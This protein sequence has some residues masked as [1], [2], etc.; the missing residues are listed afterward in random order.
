EYAIRFREDLD[1]F[2]SLT[3]CSPADHVFLPTAHGR[4]LCA[5]LEL[6]A[7]WP[8]AAQ[9]SFHLEFRH[10]LSLEGDGALSEE[11]SYCAA[12]GAFFEYART[13]PANDKCRCYTDSSDLS[14]EYARISG[15]EFGVLPIPF[16]AQL[17]DRR[18]RA[19]DPLC[20]GYVG[21]ARQE[22]GFHWLPGLVETIL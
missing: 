12:H 13:F 21:D 3:G 20:I 11:N 14:E 6:M 9:P 18:T 8:P 7:T 10:A 16:R 22:K 17:L 19:N 2:L 15:L 4:E 1:R 5:I